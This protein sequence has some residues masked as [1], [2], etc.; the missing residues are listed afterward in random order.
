M[1]ILG[2]S[3]KDILTFFSNDN[4]NHKFSDFHMNV[5]IV[6]EGKIRD[7]SVQLFTAE[8]I[9]R[10]SPF[11]SIDIIE[12]GE[13]SKFFDKY[14]KSQPYGEVFVGLDAKGRKFDS[15]AFAG[16]FDEK[17]LST[18]TLYFVIGEAE[19]LS[20][21]ARNV[22]SEYVSLSDMIF[23]YRVSLMVLAEQIYRAMTIITGHPY[24]K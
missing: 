21:K 13:N 22:I 11:F 5:K 12:T 19:G 17:R 14:G 16:W 1:G 7:K 2:F 6:V 18:K 20:E 15:L 24:H 9:K 23:S 10:L 4:I 8:Y 3:V